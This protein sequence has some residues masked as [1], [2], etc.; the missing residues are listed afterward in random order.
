VAK[1]GGGG[2]EEGISIGSFVGYAPV[3]DSRFVVLAKIDNPKDVIWAES[4]AAPMF[5]SMMRFLL[6]YAKIEPT[7]PMDVQETANELNGEREVE[8]EEQGV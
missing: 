8:D 2:Y 6:S 5:G 7:E 4:S 1:E 3:H